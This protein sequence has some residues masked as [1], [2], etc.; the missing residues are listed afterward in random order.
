MSPT[1][2]R[3]GRSGPSHRFVVQ[4]DEEDS[5]YWLA[6]WTED[7]RVHTFARSL[8]D[9][10]ALAQDALALWFH[11]DAETIEVTL[12]VE[13]P[14]DVKADIVELSEL[15]G[16]LDSVQAEV[17]MRQRELV[18]RL[19]EEQGL[20]YRDAAQLLGISHQRV[21]QLVKESA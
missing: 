21:A 2:D 19:V 6:H 15:R 17:I 1:R 20:T 12:D 18:H 4:R 8:N 16:E 9:V 7:D 5:R 11:V 14:H 10:A 13:L 3:A